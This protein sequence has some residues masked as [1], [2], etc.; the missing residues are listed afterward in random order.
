M[1]PPLSLPQPSPQHGY[2]CKIWIARELEEQHLGGRHYVWFS[3]EFNPFHKGD[4]SNPAWLYLTI[5]RAV[6]HGDRNHPKIRELRRKLRE[7]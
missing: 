4:S 3:R 1:P 2:A 7:W 6:K 5:D